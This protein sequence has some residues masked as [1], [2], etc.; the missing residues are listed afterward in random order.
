MIWCVKL[1]GSIFSEHVP[2]DYY[3]ADDTLEFV[4]RSCQSSWRTLFF[5]MARIFRL[6]GTLSSA[7][8]C[9][10]FSYTLSKSSFEPR[11]GSPETPFVFYLSTEDQGCLRCKPRRAAYTAWDRFEQSPLMYSQ[12]AQTHSRRNKVSSAVSSKPLPQRVQ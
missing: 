9:G 4:G 12:S 8:D 6:M 2:N 10:L 11:L 1:K 5:G 3:C 7:M